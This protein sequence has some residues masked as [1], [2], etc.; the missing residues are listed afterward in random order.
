MAGNLQAILRSAVMKFLLPDV[1]TK[2]CCLL[3]LSHHP[4]LSTRLSS[5]KAALQMSVLHSS[6]LLINPSV[7]PLILSSGCRSPGPGLGTL[8]VECVSPVLCLIRKAVGAETLLI[9]SGPAHPLWMTD[10]T[11]EGC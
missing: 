2:N 7:S 5:S 10:H 9:T 3:I 4:L 8:G 11:E 1:K 6:P